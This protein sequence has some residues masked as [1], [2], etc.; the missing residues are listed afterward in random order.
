MTPDVFDPAV[1]ARGVPHESL[2]QLR[3]DD[4]VSWQPEPAVLGWDAGPGFWAVTRHADVRTVL[5]APGIYSSWLGAT[6]IRDPDPED[7]DVIRRM[8]LNMDAPEHGRLRRTVTAVFTRR[9]MEA[10]TAVIR[11]RAAALLDAVAP[12]RACDL[13]REVTDDFPLVNLA[14]LLGVPASD[15]SL[16]LG[17]TNR[18]IGYQDPEHATTTDD[19]HGRPVNPRSPRALQDMFAYADALAADKRAHPGDDLMTALV[20]AEVDGRA[21][22]GTELR[23]FFFLLVIAGNDTVRSISSMATGSLLGSA[24]N[25]R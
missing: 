14:D 6:Q 25:E 20:H 22:T 16:L 5:R 12:A 7:L 13:P 11:A 15:R 23:M 1:F 24:R 9:R 4:P 18:V 19:D 8:I 10:L 3:D 2:R 17:W 21:L